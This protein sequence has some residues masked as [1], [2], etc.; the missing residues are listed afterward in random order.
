[1]KI[2]EDLIEEFARRTGYDKI[3]ENPPVG[4]RPPAPDEPGY[5]DAIRLVRFLSKKGWR[6]AKNYSFCDPGAYREILGE[7]LFLEEILQIQNKTGK[8]P[9]LKQESGTLKGA[10]Q[11]KHDPASARR[12]A[13]S[14]ENPLSLRLSLM[15]PL[16]A[17]DLVRNMI[18]NF[19]HNNK[20]GQLFEWGT[21]FWK[22]EKAGYS[23]GRHLGLCAWGKPIDLWQNKPAPWV[24]SLKS[25]LNGL[26]ENLSLKGLNWHRPPGDIPFLHPGQ[27]LILRRNKIPVG[28][29]GSLHPALLKKHKIPV[30]AALAEVDLSFL[31]TRPKKALLFKTPPALPTVE[32]DL[33]FVIPNDK[34]ADEVRREIQKSLGPLCEKVSAFDIYE[35]QGGRSVSFRIA[36]LPQSQ[37]AYT[38]Q[39]IQKLMDRVI[40][41]IQNKLSV[42]LK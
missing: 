29:L 39:E 22:E 10:L 5:W 23:E 42:R 19:R 2:K 33:C 24:Y 12:R 11:K 38:D 26:F 16:L 31:K 17:P 36:L 4:V 35:D 34:E 7:R 21:V 14:I 15:K 6:E 13:F 27:S 40:Q 3:P 41:D 8:G 37:K 28:F 30:D 32:R 18:R 20:Y 25:A 9:P 1:M